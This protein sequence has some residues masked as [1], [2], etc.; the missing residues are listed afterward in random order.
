[1]RVGEGWAKK[2]TNKKKTMWCA[3][4]SVTNNRLKGGNNNLCA[5]LQA[6]NLERSWISDLIYSSGRYSF[7]T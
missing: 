4:I 7:F 5:L 2:K 1:M 3:A 6:L